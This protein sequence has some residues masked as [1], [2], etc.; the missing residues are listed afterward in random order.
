[1]RLKQL[2]GRTVVSANDD[3]S[4]VKLHRAD[5]G[6]GIEKHLRGVREPT[7]F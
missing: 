6:D 3:A 7:V 2:R 5:F 1:L 4:V